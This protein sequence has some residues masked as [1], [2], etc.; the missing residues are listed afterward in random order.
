MT[1]RWF[2]LTCGECKTTLDRDTA[3][4][5]FADADRLGWATRPNKKAGTS[6]P[7]CFECVLKATEG[8]KEYE[9]AMNNF[10]QGAAK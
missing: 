3:E 5:L 6:S 7:V 9:L 10:L 4:V 2:S 1:G 8:S